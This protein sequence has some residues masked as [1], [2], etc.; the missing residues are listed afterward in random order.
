MNILNLAACLLTT[1]LSVVGFPDWGLIL[2]SKNI[3]ETIIIKSNL[4]ATYFRVISRNIK[5][6]SSVIMI[7]STVLTRVLSTNKHNPVEG[8][9]PHKAVF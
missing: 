5:I 4:F 6:T 7:D 8:D 2:A 9:R 3:V 1:Y